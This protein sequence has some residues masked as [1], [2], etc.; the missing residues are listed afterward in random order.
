MPV[1]ALPPGAADG[2]TLRSVHLPR[3]AKVLI[4]IGIFFALVFTAYVIVAEAF[5]RSTAEAQIA[6][7]LKR[8]YNLEELPAVTIKGSPFFWRVMTGHFDSVE[9]KMKKLDTSQFATGQDRFSSPMKISEMDIRLDG[10]N[11]SPTSILD[12]QKA[13]A[14]ENGTLTAHV[15][16][17]DLNEYLRSSG[18]RVTFKLN[19]GEVTAQTQLAGQ[20]QTFPVSGKGVFVLKDSE[21]IFDPASVQGEGVSPEVAQNALH[22]RRSLPSIGGVRIATL[23][24]G[25]GELILKAEV[26]AFTFEAP[27]QDLSPPGETESPSPSLS[28]S[29]S[30]LPSA[31]PSR[32]PSPTRSAT[33]TPSPT[34]TKK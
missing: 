3:Y 8:Y 17:A 20:G 10:I 2:P 34:S 6:K 5:L 21:L 1:A 27:A 31:S 29:S 14:A 33:K 19:P 15:T 25:Q 28:P 16:E 24:V 9:A 26:S 30:P 23:E 13:F 18:V 32:S 4:W 22:V 12:G 11:F 7:D